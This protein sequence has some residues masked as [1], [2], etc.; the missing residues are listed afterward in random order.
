MPQGMQDN[1]GGVIDNFLVMAV[2]FCHGQGNEQKPGVYPRGFLK[3]AWALNL[4]NEAEGWI[5]LPDFPARADRDSPPARSPPAARV[6][7]ARIAILVGAVVYPVRSWN[8]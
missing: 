5:D 3:K 2:G 1:D 8:G 6:Q 4:E 7:P